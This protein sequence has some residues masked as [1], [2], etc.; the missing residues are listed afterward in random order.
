MLRAL[1]CS[2][3]PAAEAM[4]NTKLL[5]ERIEKSDFSGAKESMGNLN[6]TG[7]QN[8]VLDIGKLITENIMNRKEGLTH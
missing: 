4:L 5:S 1:A 6:T 2:R 7:S 8:E 3:A